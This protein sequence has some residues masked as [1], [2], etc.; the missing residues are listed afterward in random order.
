MSATTR[1]GEQTSKRTPQPKAEVF[2]STSGP[3]TSRNSEPAPGVERN[4]NEQVRGNQG[5]GLD[6]YSERRKGVSSKSG[7]RRMVIYDK[8]MATLNPHVN[9][10]NRIRDVG[11]VKTPSPTT[12]SP[13]IATKG[14][15]SSSSTTSSSARKVDST[16]DGKPV[17]SH[18]RGG[19]SL[20]QTSTRTHRS[21]PTSSSSSSSESVRR[22]ARDHSSPSSA[23]S[24]NS[25]HDT[26]YSSSSTKVPVE[27]N[28]NKI[29]GYP[30]ASTSEQHQRN[31]TPERSLPHAHSEQKPLYD[32]KEDYTWD[33]SQESLPGEW[34]V[35]VDENLLWTDDDKLRKSITTCFVRHES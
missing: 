35:S 6:S 5:V 8:E 25:S 22:Q 24:N 23:V 18:S 2:P 16:S 34:E 11:N 1:S 15:S 21:N 20:K 27:S 32:E 10:K 12:S 7:G 17:Q 4:R 14:V 33:S 13:P 29:I 3:G 28:W 26:R 30:N 31:K 9:Q 19:R